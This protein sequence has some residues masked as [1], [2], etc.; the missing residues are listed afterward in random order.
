M[1]KKIHAGDE[2]RSIRHTVAYLNTH[3]GIGTVTRE[4]EDIQWW[5]QTMAQFYPFFNNPKARYTEEDYRLMGE[6]KGRMCGDL[7]E[8]DWVAWDKDRMIRD[9]R[10]RYWGE[11]VNGK[12][13]KVANHRE[14]RIRVCKECG[15]VLRT[16][17]G[18]HDCKGDYVRYIADFPVYSMKSDASAARSFID[19]KRKQMHAEGEDFTDLVQLMPTAICTK[20]LDLPESSDIITDSPFL[21]GDEFFLE[22]QRQ[23]CAVK[24][25]MDGNTAE[26]GLDDD[27]L[28]S[29]PSSADDVSEAPSNNGNINE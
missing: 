17:D 2:I 23:A 1:I 24:Y 25:G 9:I 5:H 4:I 22:R 19:R 21:E 3:M 28:L 27:E 12:L 6:G 7:S 20:E 11:V 8:K 14:Y 15:S 13:V 18:V 10:T 16:Y 26:R 29:K